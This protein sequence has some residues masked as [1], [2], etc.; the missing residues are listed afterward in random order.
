MYQDNQSLI[1]Y[2]VI[3]LVAMVINLVL[4]SLITQVGSITPKNESS[5]RSSNLVDDYYALYDTFLT[6]ENSIELREVAGND[7]IQLSDNLLLE[8]YKQ[9]DKIE[10][11]AVL[12]GGINQS[13]DNSYSFDLRFLPSDQLYRCNVIKSNISEGIQLTMELV[14]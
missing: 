11:Q 7:Y 13:N 12:V 9:T 1:K 14:K 2:A 4:I 10:R 5:V 3:S 6:I 8:R